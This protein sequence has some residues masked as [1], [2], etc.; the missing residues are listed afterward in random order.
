[1]PGFVGRDVASICWQA[2]TR[3]PVPLISQRGRLG[4]LDR[5]VEGFDHQ[6][7]VGGV[8]GRKMAHT[9]AACF[10]D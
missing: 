5:V 6:A 7:L 9:F 2:V 10:S 4:R 3:K 1:M 8:G